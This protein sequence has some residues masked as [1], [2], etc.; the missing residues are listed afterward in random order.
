MARAV[1]VDENEQH[2]PA[3]RRVHEYLVTELRTLH[4]GVNPAWPPRGLRD[5]HGAVLSGSHTHRRLKISAAAHTART[6]RD[7]LTLNLATV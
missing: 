2:G 7:C 4:D 3:R 5:A 6:A 1:A